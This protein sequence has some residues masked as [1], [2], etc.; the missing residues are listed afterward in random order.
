MPLHIPILPGDKVMMLG[1]E[2]RGAFVGRGGSRKPSLESLCSFLDSP[3]SGYRRVQ[4]VYK[5]GKSRVI[6]EAFSEH[7]SKGTEMN[8]PMLERFIYGTFGVEGLITAFASMDNAFKRPRRVHQDAVRRH[9]EKKYKGQGKVLISLS[10]EAIHKS[11]VLLGPLVMGA[12]TRLTLKWVFEERSHSGEIEFG[13]ATFEKPVLTREAVQVSALAAEEV[14]ELIDF[15]LEG[16]MC[17]WPAT[18]TSRVME[19]LASFCGGHPDLINTICG[20]FLGTQGLSPL[21]EDWKSALESAMFAT[22]VDLGKQRGREKG[23]KEKIARICRDLSMDAQDQVR[24]IVKGLVQVV[25]KPYIRDELW[26]AGLATKEGSLAGV[27]LAFHGDAKG[28]G[29]G[30][31]TAS[32]G[33]GVPVNNGSVP[34][35]QHG[36]APALQERAPRER[37]CV[38]VKAGLK[39]LWESP[40][41]ANDSVAALQNRFD[42]VSSLLKGP[43]GVLVPPNIEEVIKETRLDPSNW[44]KVDLAV[45]KIIEWMEKI[46]R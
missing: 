23:I 41:K 40:G 46:D 11:H 38:F 7:T 20:W 27:V 36:E 30:S 25:Q 18:L 26:K 34:G 21:T 1:Q 31:S 5:I 2:E 3:D 44:V 37:V 22:L 4:G 16:M 8:E 13:S 9:L 29:V 33:G 10:V 24:G 6:G 42:S 14:L 17:D 19:A 12:S 32:Q 39:L 45:K 35:D 15:H 28:A 43:E